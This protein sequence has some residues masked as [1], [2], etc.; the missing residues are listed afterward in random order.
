MNSS[1]NVVV[2]GG[3]SGIGYGIAA[4]FAREGHRVVIADIEQARAE[5]AAAE[6]RAGGAG[7]SA[8]RVDV[9][10]AG[11]VERLARAIV[12]RDGAPGIL[13]VNAGVLVRK[14]LLESTPD[15]WRWLYGVNVFGGVNT[16]RAFLPAMIA[17]GG[18][19]VVVTASMASLRG[20]SVVGSSLYTSSKWALLALAD[21]LSQE[22]E[23]Q[24]IRFTFVC[25]GGVATGLWQAERNRPG[26]QAPG[27]PPSAADRSRDGLGDDVLEPLEVGRLVVAGVRNGRRYIITHPHQ[28]PAV[29]KWQQGI[30]AAFAEA[31][32]A[33]TPND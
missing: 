15:D 24:N 23:T 14:P 16:L 2:T 27:A 29:E 20:A 21:G 12:Q 28:W 7:A 11:D 17:G 6:L 1:N 31:R 13:C 3:A 10:D 9:A 33:S 5:A 22:V 19:H 18:G 32:A 4:A 25:P 30:A 8:E 26:H